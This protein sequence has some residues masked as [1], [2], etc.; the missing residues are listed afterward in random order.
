MQA[1]RRCSQWQG[2]QGRGEGGAGRRVKQ[3]WRNGVVAWCGSSM[4][5]LELGGDGQNLTWCNL[6]RGPAAGEAAPKGTLLFQSAEIV[7]VDYS[8]RAP[9]GP[10]PGPTN[11]GSGARVRRVEGSSSDKWLPLGAKGRE[12]CPEHAHLHDR[13]LD[14]SFAASAC[15]SCAP[16]VL[17]TH[18]FGFCLHYGLILA[19]LLLLLGHRPLPPPAVCCIHPSFRPGSTARSKRAF[20]PSQARSH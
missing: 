4:G 7:Y 16:N 1:Q 13:R 8:L 6:N 3:A 14:T 5:E 17:R 10:E 18:R 20:S 11:M 12:C 9:P 2:V 19:P 15:L